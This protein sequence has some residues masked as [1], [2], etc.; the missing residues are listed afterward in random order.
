MT[1]YLTLRYPTGAQQTLTF[2]SAFSRALIVITA[3]PYADVIRQ[4]ETDEAFV[5]RVDRER[6]SDQP[7]TAAQ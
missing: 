2:P 7:L 1:W 6:L 5:P 4:W 3:S